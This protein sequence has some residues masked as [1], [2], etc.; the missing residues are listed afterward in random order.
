[1][2]ATDTATAGAP[3]L[4]FVRRRQCGVSRKME[5]LVAWIAVTRKQQLRVVWL[6]ADA[7]P[8]LADRLHVDAVPSVILI[9]DGR[10]VGQ[11][12]GR[13]TGR[14]IDALIEDHLGSAA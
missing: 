5:S 7:F 14:Q 13:S 12:E 8:D 9:K 4:V 3:V 6:D 11:L 1:M 2:P 10:V